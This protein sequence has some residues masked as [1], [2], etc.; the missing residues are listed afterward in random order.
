MLK[1]LVRKPAKLQ[2]FLKYNKPKDKKFGKD[3][4]RC[5]RCGRRGAHIRK[6]GLNVCRQCFREIAKEI[7]FK[8]YGHEV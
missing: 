5:T 1:Q 3:V 6:Y 7:G 8:K 2:R 4:R